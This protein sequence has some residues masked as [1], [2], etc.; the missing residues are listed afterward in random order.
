MSQVSSDK[1]AVWD[2]VKASPIQAEHTPRQELIGWVLITVLIVVSVIA[3]CLLWV[4]ADGT[5]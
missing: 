4:K 5:L 2:D 1:S 3:L